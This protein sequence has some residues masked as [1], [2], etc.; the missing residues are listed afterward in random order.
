[1]VCRLSPALPWLWRRGLPL[2][3]HSPN[4]TVQFLS[5]LSLE[6]LLQRYALV[7]CDLAFLLVVSDREV[8]SLI[9]LMS[10]YPNLVVILQHYQFL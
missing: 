5:R 9:A 6:S 4:H 2:D 1:M 8:Q 10:D 7:I 3:L